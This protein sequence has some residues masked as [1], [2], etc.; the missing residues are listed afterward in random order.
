MKNTLKKVLCIGLCIIAL[1][2]LSGCTGNNELT[3]DN[4]T[5]TVETSVEALKNF[6]EKKLEK[7]VDS[8]TLKYIIKFANGHEQ[9]ADLGRAIFENLDIEISSIDLE[10]QTVTVE[11]LNKDLYAA[12]SD[13]TSE[14]T[15]NFSGL[16]LLGK[17]G[18]DDFL[19]FHLSELV[20]AI[21]KSSM[22]TQPVSVVLKITQDKRNL[23]L[24]F[25]EDAED[26]VSGGALTAIKSIIGGVK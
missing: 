23:V 3:E 15:S 14:L 12:A 13:F 20:E 6:D 7:Y 16:Q 8:S 19:D 18:D 2:S 4:V 1:F 10:N 11:V 22:C 21:D 5:K 17:L 24:S 26:A 25:D 9:F